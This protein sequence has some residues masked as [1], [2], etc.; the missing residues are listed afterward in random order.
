MSDHI[1]RKVQ[2]KMIFYSWFIVISCGFGCQS[3]TITNQQLFIELDKPNIIEEHYIKMPIGASS[4]NVAKVY[5]VDGKPFLFL[6]VYP[7]YT[8]FVYDL[9]TDSLVKEIKIK[10]LSLLDI[11]FI[12]KD[13]ILLFGSSS[14]G[15]NDS[16]LRSINLSGDINRVYPLINSNVISSKFPASDLCN[17]GNEIYPYTIA[18]LK[19]KIFISFRYSYYGY[20]GYKNRHPIIGYYDLIKDTLIMNHKIWYPNLKDGVYYKWNMYETY[21]SINQRGNVIISFQYTPTFYEWNYKMN[22]LD[23]HSVCSQFMEPIP[24]A[25]KLYKNDDVYNDYKYYN[26]AYL[27]IKSIN[28]SDNKYIYYRDILL[29][30]KKYGDMKYLRVFFNENYEYIGESLIGINDLQI[31]KYKKHIILTTIENGNIVVRFTKPSFKSFNKDA[32]KERLDSIS[33]AKVEAE[34]KEKMGLCNII[35]FNTDCFE[36][37]TN[38]ILKYINYSHNIFDTS[39]VLLL[40]NKDGCGSC[41]NYILDFVMNNQG[42]LYN[43][44]DIPFYVLYV[45]E[46]STIKDVFDYL[47]TY[48]IFD[49]TH[50]KADTSILYK[51]FHPY[52]MYNPRLVIIS[53]KKVIFDEIYMPN[54]MEQCANKIFNYLGF[55]I[56]K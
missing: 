31:Q 2:K 47:G 11:E 24:Y 43:T 55:I 33:K 26:G 46:N 41:N 7:F 22:K 42:L 56:D 21:I 37:K 14:N 48:K 39:F 40:I 9:A 44:K 30:I 6:R 13:N 12:N 28:L 3:Q 36:Y 20:K 18:V 23:T 17:N 19:D 45:D 10:K 35:G 29:P 4:I 32:L 25:E 34:T 16:T 15:K 50:T 51:K 53:Q 5:E 52:S 1:K 38:D 8:L 54:E 27:Q 49:K